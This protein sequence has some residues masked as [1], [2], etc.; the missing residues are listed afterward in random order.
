MTMEAKFTP[1]PWSI[2][3][4]GDD[5]DVVHDDLNAVAQDIANKTGC[6]AISPINLGSNSKI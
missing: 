4:D 1:G 5:F 6:I 3:L 2:S